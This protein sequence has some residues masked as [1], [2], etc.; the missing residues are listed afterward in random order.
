MYSFICISTHCFL[1]SLLTNDIDTYEIKLSKEGMLSFKGR[2]LSQGGDFSAHK[3]SLA[4]P[5]FIEVPVPSQESERLSIC[6]FYNCSIRCWNCTDN[7]VCFVF[8]FFLLLLLLLYISVSMHD[9]TLLRNRKKHHLINIHLL[10]HM[11]Y[12]VLFGI[13]YYYYL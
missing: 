1:A 5:L 4:P 3:T 10:Y 9:G 8:H 7:V 12:F 2:L 13:G 11:L 6:K